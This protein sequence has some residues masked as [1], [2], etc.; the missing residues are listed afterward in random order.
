MGYFS[1]PKVSL[2]VCNRA[3]LLNVCRVVNAEVTEPVPAV[4]ALL[5]G[6]Q[7]PGTRLS[8]YVSMPLKIPL[9]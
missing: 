5:R 1:L 4:S 3:A 9:E 6:F 2:L 7:N 8:T